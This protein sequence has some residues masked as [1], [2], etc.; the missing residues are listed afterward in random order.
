MSSSKV[1]S[2]SA[3]ESDSTIHSTNQLY[4]PTHS[5][6]TTPPPIL[7]EVP[8]AKQAQ[9]EHDSN[10]ADPFVATEP[11]ARNAASLSSV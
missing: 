5:A 6:N 4:T 1:M 11:L 9:P 7:T 3:D 2:S 10:E 8:T